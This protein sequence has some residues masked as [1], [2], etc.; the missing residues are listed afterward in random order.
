M[1]EQKR[2][3]FCSVGSKMNLQ[4]FADLNDII[5]NNAEAFE[6]VDLE[7]TFNPIATKLSELGYEVLINHKEKAEF[8]PASRL[9][10]VV[11]QRDA[12]KQKVEELNVTLTDLQSKAGDNQ[13]LK[14]DYQKLIDQNKIL[15]EDLETTRLETEIMIT[16]K[17]AINPKDL[18]L[19]INKDN[20]QKNAKGEFMGIDAEIARIKTE[21]PYLFQG[22]KQNNKG[23]MDNSGN[24]ERQKPVGMNAMIRR[25][26]GLF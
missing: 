6:G 13:Q 17:D 22:E 11:G 26:A 15:L 5:T 8:V 16:A 2:V 10:E 9:G 7:Q 14:D 24:D 18:L 1:K 3:M 20:I 12:F 25:K 4:M 21:R 19:F 23:G